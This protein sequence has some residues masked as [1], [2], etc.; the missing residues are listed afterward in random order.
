M[1]KQHTIFLIIILFSFNCRKPYNPH[2]INSP[3]SYL[4]VE[5]VINT[6]ADSTI[7]K[8]SRTVNISAGVT[9]NPET[10]AIVIVQSNSNDSYLLKEI[11]PGN[12]A[13]PSLNINNTKQYRLSI[14]TTD[15]QQYLSDFV[16][17]TISPPIDSVGFNI[18]NNGMQIYV[19]T[20]DASNST[21]YFRW[22]YQETW[23]F[24]SK[25]ESG[26][27]TNGKEIVQRDASQQVY[28]CFGNNNSDVIV[29]GSSANLSQ[30]IIYQNTILNIAST[31]EK[32]ETKYSILVHQYALTPDAY[33]F[34][35]NLKKNTEQLGGIFDAQPSEIAGNIHN[36][37]NPSLPA[38]GY[39]S[40]CS[41]QTK[42]VF[43]TNAE[44]PQTWQV[45]Y[46]YDC[47]LDSEYF[48]N[49]HTQ[50]HANQ[51]SLFLVPL[52]ASEI[53]INQF[54]ALGGGYTASTQFC[55]D[56]TL[57]GTKIQPPFWK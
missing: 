21:H 36:T 55:I 30:D 10:N 16:P 13:V 44:L 18:L 3:A 52:G 48:A 17:V 6:G 51:V 56:C 40:A 34:F 24:H 7:I 22:D 43:I 39:L 23:Q 15:N 20:H 47:S 27:I 29:L 1:I 41:T 50:D 9:N 33:I 45:S 5:G 35:Q 57:R 46:P 37:S 53:P 28:N 26:Y 38:I 32:I 25:F 12:Y 8:L 4:V 31:S 19:N 11:S 42:R 14:K 49:P 54:S 2:V